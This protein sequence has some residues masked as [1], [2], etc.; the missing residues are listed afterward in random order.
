M[1]ASVRNSFE[2]W[3]HL[4]DQN[5]LW[6]QLDSIV[7]SFRSYVDDNLGALVNAGVASADLALI[8]TQFIINES[9]A[10]WQIAAMEIDSVTDASDLTFRHV[11]DQQPFLVS[12]PVTIQNPGALPRPPELLR[13]DGTIS[14]AL[15][16]R[17]TQRL[18]TLGVHLVGYTSKKSPR[19]D[20]LVLGIP[21]LREAILAFEEFDKPQ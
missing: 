19:V 17:L 4:S 8:E 7:E 3:R 9:L 15:V 12:V 16:K 18:A 10:P 14:P 20:A 13:T 1:H 2:L 11:K 21:E 5:P 6:A